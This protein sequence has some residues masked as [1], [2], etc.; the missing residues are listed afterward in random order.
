[1][2]TLDKK[3]EAGKVQ[4]DWCVFCLPQSWQDC[5]YSRFQVNRDLRDELETWILGDIFL[6]LYFSVFDQEN[7]RIGLAP[8][9]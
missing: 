8:S 5:W 2:P 3:G 1:M 7:G 9:V 4:A 6:R